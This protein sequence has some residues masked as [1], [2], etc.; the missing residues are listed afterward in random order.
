[1]SI[2]NYFKTRSIKLD[3]VNP[4]NTIPDEPVVDSD[5]NHSND[6]TIC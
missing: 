6:A 2:T 5:K 1:M 4:N 3:D